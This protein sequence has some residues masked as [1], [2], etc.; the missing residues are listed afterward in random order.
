MHNVGRGVIKLLKQGEEYNLSFPNGY[1]RSILTVP[2]I[3]LG[4][5]TTITCPQTGY[6]A[7]IEFLTKPFYGGK[8][9]RITC[10][11]HQPG[12][13]KPFV[14]ITGEW[15]GAMEAKWDDGVMRFI[16]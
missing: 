16:L 9:N 10:Q 15:C 3:E 2:W 7:N 6:H 5:S 4:G 13:K 11:I 1:A 14:S 12:S 8:K